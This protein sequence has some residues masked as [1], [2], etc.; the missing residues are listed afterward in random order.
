MKHFLHQLLLLACCWLGWA[1]AAQA[2]PKFGLAPTDAFIEATA[3]D[4]E[5]TLALL[6]R[7]DLPTDACHLDKFYELNSLSAKQALHRDRNYRLPLLRFDYDGKSIRSTIGREDLVLAKAVQAYNRERQQAGQQAKSYEQSRELWVPYGLLRCTAKATFASTSSKASVPS[8]KKSSAKPAKSAKAEPKPV[9]EGEAK[10]AGGYAIFG[11]EHAKIERV[12]GKLAGQHYYLIAGHGGPDPGAMARVNEH[13]ICE[14]EYAYD[15]LLRLA[16]GI[17]SH[18][19]VPYI[20]VR[21]P[22]DGI[23][24]AT[25]LKC[26]YDEEAWGEKNIPRDQLLRLAQRTDAVNALAKKAKARGAKAQ[27]CIEIHVDSRHAE[28]QT[29]LYFY[30]QR[31]SDESEDTAECIREAMARNYAKSGRTR[32]Y[33]GDIRARELYT[34][35]ETNIPTIYIELGNI[36]HEFDQQRVL[37]PTNR[38]VLADWFVEGLLD[39]TAER[40]KR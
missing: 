20:I 32:E 2:G 17:I 39:R 12:D 26:D 18:G 5:G 21:D 34:L 1:Q 6:R 36:Q 31:K 15:V 28:R 33:E 22:D 29:D 24:D 4:G 16:R 14:D 35:R 9:E 11:P 40:A 8:E 3:L 7:Y 30:H 25:Y 38:Q 23:R 37:K 13:R 10:L 27:Y 19:G